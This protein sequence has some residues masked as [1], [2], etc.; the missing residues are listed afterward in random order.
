M[1]LSYFK[2]NFEYVFIKH[3]YAGEDMYEKGKISLLLRNRWPARFASLLE[4]NFK[5]KNC[6]VQ[7]LPLEVKLIEEA[8]KDGT[9]GV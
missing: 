2:K 7:V 5:N 4:Q 9:L 1:Q 3:S 6:E 8:K